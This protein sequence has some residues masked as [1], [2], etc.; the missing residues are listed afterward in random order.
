MFGNE[1]G[2]IAFTTD[3]REDAS[4]YADLMTRNTES[5]TFTVVARQ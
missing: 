5:S 4:I 1:S 2:S 3:S